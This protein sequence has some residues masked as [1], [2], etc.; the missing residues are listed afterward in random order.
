MAENGW[1][2]YNQKY[3]KSAGQQK[4]DAEA[5]EKGAVNRRVSG[6]DEIMGQLKSAWLNM[7]SD[8]D[9]KAAEHKQ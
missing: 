9:K 6:P 7:S 2:E 5:A 3:G 8:K 4:A 1:S